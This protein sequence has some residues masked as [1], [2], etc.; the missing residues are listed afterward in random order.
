MHFFKKKL[1][2]LT[3]NYYFFMADTDEKSENIAFL[4]FKKKFSF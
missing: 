4:C 2:L 3:N 1:V